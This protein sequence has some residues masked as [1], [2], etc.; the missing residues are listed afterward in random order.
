[1]SFIQEKIFLH[2]VAD[3][4]FP[5]VEALLRGVHVAV[6]IVVPV[7]AQ[8]EEGEDEAV[9][10]GVFRL[11]TALAENVSQRVDEERA[12]H[13]ATVLMKKPHTKSCAPLLAESGSPGLK[14]PAHEPEG[15]A[16]QQ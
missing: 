1:M 15:D 2:V 9:A 8:S 12:V 14:S 10:A 4:D 3:V 7:F 6:V 13:R 16:A 11:E 5:P